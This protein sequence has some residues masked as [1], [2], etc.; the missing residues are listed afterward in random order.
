MGWGGGEDPEEPKQSW[1]EM[2]NWRNQPL[3]LQTIL[4][5]HYGTDTKTET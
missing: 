3:W 4:P 5:R 2:W 1:K